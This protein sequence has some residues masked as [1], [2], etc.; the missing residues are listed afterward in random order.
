M[1]QE[2]TPR[3]T[4]MGVL[5]GYLPMLVSPTGGSYRIGGP[6]QAHRKNTRFL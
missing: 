2:I 5:L 3:I 1:A 4:Q 6:A